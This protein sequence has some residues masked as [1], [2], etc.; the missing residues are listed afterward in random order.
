MHVDIWQLLA[1]L[2]CA[3][4]NDSAVALAGPVLGFLM[5]VFS[6][7]SE[8]FKRYSKTH[9]FVLLLS[10]L[11]AKALRFFSK[12]TM[13]ILPFPLLAL[14]QGEELIPWSHGLVLK[15]CCHARLILLLSALNLLQAVVGVC[16]CHT[17]LAPGAKPHTAF[18]PRT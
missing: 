10:P 17:S 8:R 5:V 15:H 18:T 11:E 3:D 12:G 9:I 16:C 1:K 14:K 6:M 7:L 4:E 13:L 2:R